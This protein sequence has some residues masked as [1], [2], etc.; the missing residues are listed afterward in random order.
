MPDLYYY[1]AT[2]N[3]TTIVRMNNQ[4]EFINWLDIELKGEQAISC[5]DLIWRKVIQ[6]KTASKRT[7]I[8]LETT[9]N[10]WTRWRLRLVR[11]PSRAM[12]LMGHQWFPSD[13]EILLKKWAS[14]GIKMFNNITKRG[15]L[16]QKQKLEWKTNGAMLWMHYFQLRAT[17]NSPKL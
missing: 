13:I 7:N 1:Y 9:L 14:S 4:P 11:R 2:T 6:T 16:L 3:L 10:I 5:Q 15:T 17:I 8:Y 12:P